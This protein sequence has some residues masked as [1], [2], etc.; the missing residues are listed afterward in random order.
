MTDTEFLEGITSYDLE[1]ERV[2]Q[3]I[4]EKN[5]KIVAIQLPDGLKQYANKITEEIEKATNIQV[6]IWGGS[7]YGACDLAVDVERL[8]VDLLIAWGHKEWVY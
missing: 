8:G 3:S 2:I 6:I 1:I 4:K 5:A 7:C